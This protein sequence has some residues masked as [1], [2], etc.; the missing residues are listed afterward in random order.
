MTIP[1][2]QQVEAYFRA[3]LSEALTLFDYSNVSIQAR[4][5]KN[6]PEPTMEFGIYVNQ[7]IGSI[8]R[9]SLTDCINHALE[10]SAKKP[11]SQ[12]LREK[13]AELIASAEKLENQTA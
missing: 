12:L 2:D 9:K 7:A 5:F 3:K 10:L 4:A 11:E 8:Y 13:A 6:M 1:T